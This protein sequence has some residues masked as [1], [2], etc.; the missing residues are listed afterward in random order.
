M[1]PLNRKP[2]TVA[3]KNSIKGFARQGKYTGE[4]IAR[5][6][7]TAAT[8]ITAEAGDMGKADGKP[9][10]HQNLSVI[11]GLA[12]KHLCDMAFNLCA[13]VSQGIDIT[14]GAGITEDTI[15]YLMREMHQLL[16][17]SGFEG[18]KVIMKKLPQPP[19]EMSH[20]GN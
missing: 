5:L 3:Q 14:E 18:G 4:M 19:P 1:I 9:L 8:Q 7:M 10:A 2:L 17:E 16:V 12:M 13:A 11:H 15:E 6:C 20:G